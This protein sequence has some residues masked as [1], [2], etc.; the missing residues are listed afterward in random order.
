M[1]LFAVEFARDLRDRGAGLAT[2]LCA[3]IPAVA[4]DISVMEFPVYSL[5][6]L[7]QTAA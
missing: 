2:C 5:A 3:W 6:G 4:D 1:H 7:V